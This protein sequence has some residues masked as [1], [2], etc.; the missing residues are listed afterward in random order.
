MPFIKHF[1]V[2]HLWTQCRVVSLCPHLVVGWDN[3]MN[4]TQKWHVP[5]NCWWDIPECSF[6]IRHNS[7]QCWRL[8]LICYPV[9]LSEYSEQRLLLILED[10]W[11]KQ[12][13]NI[14]NFKTLGS[15]YCSLLQLNQANIDWIIF[16]NVT[17]FCSLDWSL[18]GELQS[19]SPDVSVS[20]YLN[21]V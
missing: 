9:S 7:W 21:L 5:C 2:A 12:E 11:W 10:M 13:I 16:H 6:P 14:C 8:K 20:F 18:L 1:W 3:E 15:G 17:Y 19:L 4:C